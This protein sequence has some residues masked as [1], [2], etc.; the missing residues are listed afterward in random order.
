LALNFKNK[1]KIMTSIEWLE[2]KAKEFSIDLDLLDYFQQAKEM[3]RKEIIDAF[4]SGDYG[5][6]RNAVIYYNE[7]Y[8][9]KESD[10]VATQTT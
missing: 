5:N 8:G 4:Q 1:I 3:H 9:S 10:D 6:I 2:Q 7:T